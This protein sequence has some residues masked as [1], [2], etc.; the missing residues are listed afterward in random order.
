MTELTIEDCP[1]LEA[2]QSGG[3]LAAFNKAVRQ[4]A[5]FTEHFGSALDDDDCLIELK[6]QLDRVRRN[7][8]KSRYSIGFIG[9]TQSGKS[10]TVNYVL[11]VTEPEHQPCKEGSGDNT[12]STVSRLLKGERSLELRY[13]TQEQFSAKREQLC[14]SS[15]LAPETSDA[16]LLARLPQQLD[17]ARNGSAPP[18]PDGQPILE[19]DVRL[20]QQLLQAFR[21]HGNRLITEYGVVLPA[22][23]RDRSRYLNYGQGADPANPLLREALIN[24]DSEYL[25]AELQVFDLPGP[26]A[27]STVDEWTTRQYLPEMDGIM[28]F[29]SCTKLGDEA[30]ERLYGQLRWLFKERVARRVWIV[31]TRWDGPTSAALNGDG[32]ESVFSAVHKLCGDK[33]LPVSQIRFVCG[34]WYTVRD[35]EQFVTSHFE[36]RLSGA[37]KPKGLSGYSEF[38]SKFQELFDKGGIPSLRNLILTELPNDV[39]LEISSTSEEQLKRIRFD[40]CRRFANEVRRRSASTQQA[41]EANQCRAKMSEVIMAMVK[42]LPPFEQAAIQ[43]RQDLLQ[44]FDINC[45]KPE[46][47]TLFKSVP[48][49]FPIHAREL[50]KK[51]TTQVEV[52]LVPGLYGA[53]QSRFDALPDVQVMEDDGGAPMNV[54]QAW[55]YFAAKDETSINNGHSQ[56]PTFLD[57]RLF[58]P[59]IDPNSEAE[60]A[61][62]HLYREMM[63]EK[64]SLVAQQTV[65]A[66]RISLVKR[67][68]QIKQELDQL[69]RADLDGTASISSNLDGL[70]DQMKALAT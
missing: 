2:S 13:M 53:W 31:L 5:L 44:E 22:Q 47:L 43:L 26:G 9:P 38:E 63:A 50:Q 28:L 55:R 41:S 11:D 61:D 51:L 18:L 54:G 48:K 15:G 57:A 6:D 29:L 65:H 56:F 67:A 58:G 3:L 36:S 7:L 59:D 52:S 70:V 1:L 37:E 69:S 49:D 30:V 34:P 39:R 21:T 32:E 12:T 33:Q 62:G 46:A 16:D 25:P 24:F 27:K 10:T 20:L 42:E 4:V 14:T 64:I 40:L 8:T 19:H 60:L 66:I 23:Y 17:A 68:M 35:C 45:E